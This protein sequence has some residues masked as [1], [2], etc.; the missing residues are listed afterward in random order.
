ML[1]GNKGCFIFLD[2]NPIRYLL[3]LTILSIGQASC[4][5]ILMKSKPLVNST[6]MRTPYLKGFAAFVIA[7]VFLTAF[8]NFID[9]MHHADTKEFWLDEQYALKSTVQGNT[10]WG[11]LGKGALRSEANAAPL[12]YLFTKILDDVKQAVGHF[13]VSDKV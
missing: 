5:Q 3:I 10:Y 12:D 11:L 6:T 7:A 13:G 4:K 9:Q 8:C 2:C 1:G